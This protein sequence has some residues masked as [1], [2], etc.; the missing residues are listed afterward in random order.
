MNINDFG[1]FIFSMIT[2]FNR[3]IVSAVRH[4]FRQ[5]HGLVLPPQALWPNP[6]FLNNRLLLRRALQNPAPP[7]EADNAY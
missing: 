5:P 6:D 4:T 3:K 2:P 1:I 7:V